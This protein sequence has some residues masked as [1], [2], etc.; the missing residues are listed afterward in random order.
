MKK[1]YYIP[2][3]MDVVFN[4][5]GE[6]SGVQVENQ[7]YTF[8]DKNGFTETMDTADEHTGNLCVI[9]DE[10]GRVIHTRGIIPNYSDVFYIYDANYLSSILMYDYKSTLAAT[11]K[12]KY[13]DYNI[14][15]LRYSDN[16]GLSELNFSYSDGKLSEIVVYRDGDLDCYYNIEYLPTNEICV[17]QKSSTSEATSVYKN[18]E[19]DFLTLLNTLGFSYLCDFW[20]PFSFKG[21]R[22]E[23]SCERIKYISTDYVKVVTTEFTDESNYITTTYI[24]D[25]LSSIRVYKNDTLVSYKDFKMGIERTYE[26]REGMLI[27]TCINKKEHTKEVQEY[28]TGRD[29]WSDMSEELYKIIKETKTGDCTVTTVTTLPV[30]NNTKT[31]VTDTVYTD[32]SPSNHIEEKYFYTEHDNKLIGYENSTGFRWSI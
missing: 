30:L 16:D 4:E 29:N 2:E 23:R 9:R 7:M 32:G 10:R 17:E 24:D 22:Y 8:L 18:A 3:D 20:Y 31:I 26:Y 5:K 21:Q 6:I 27:A 11:C 13:L 12:L 25:A 1:E 28:L 14:H 19:Y 15:S